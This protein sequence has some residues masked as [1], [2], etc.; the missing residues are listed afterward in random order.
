NLH[1]ELPLAHH[2]SGAAACGARLRDHSPRSAAL[3][4]RPC[5]REEPLL[6]PD[7]TL[8]AALWT[9][10]RRGTGCGAAS[11]AG[12]ARLLTR[13]L[14]RGLDTSGG[15]FER[16]LQ[17]VPKIG[18]TLRTAPTTTAAPEQ[19]AEREH[20]AED[21]REI[22]EVRKHRGVESGTGPRRG[23][24]ALMPEPVVQA[25]LVRIREHRVRLRRF[26][27]LLFGAPV[28]GV[29]VRVIAHRE[30]A[31][32]ALDFHFGRRPDDAEHFVVIAFAHA[33]ATFTKAGRSSRS[34]I[35]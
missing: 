29:A 6:E 34:P 7:L 33:F 24:D 32:R 23:T 28:T 22:A 4:A 13:G 26:L 5:D 9:R 16:N 21:V 11:S 25:A 27:E 10:R 15:P 19:V 8:S 18:A 17:V 3:R 14:N 12:L 31:V 35:M 30:L 1:R 2:A 20:V